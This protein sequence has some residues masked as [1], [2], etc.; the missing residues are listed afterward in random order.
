MGMRLSDPRWFIDRSI[1]ALAAGIEKHYRQKRE[2]QERFLAGENVC[3][4]CGAERKT[5]PGAVWGCAKCG[6]MPEIY[7]SNVMIQNPRSGFK[8]A[9]FKES[10]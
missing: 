2:Y 3:P 7:G 4:E 9:G 1:P 6:W 10:E 5:D 8:L